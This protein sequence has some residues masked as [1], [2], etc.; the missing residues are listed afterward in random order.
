MK[1]KRKKSKKKIENNIEKA[2]Q[3][4]SILNNKNQ[5][6]QSFYSGLYK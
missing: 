3:S 1:S 6:F 4:A 5:T 2:T